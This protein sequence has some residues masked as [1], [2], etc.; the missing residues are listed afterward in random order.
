MPAGR[1][2]ASDL[3]TSLRGRDAPAALPSVRAL[4]ACLPWAAWT[5]FGSD[6]VKCHRDAPLPEGVDLKGPDVPRC[7]VS[8]RSSSRSSSCTGPV[9]VMPEP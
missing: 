9:R 1:A 8:F 7:L 2:S 3:A 5:V 6:R 4:T